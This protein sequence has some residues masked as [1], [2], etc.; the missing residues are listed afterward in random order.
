MLVA[1]SIR[2]IVLIEKADLDWQSGFTALTGETG[3]GKSVLLDALSLAIGQRGDAGLVRHGCPQGEVSAVF[4]LA[5]DHAV[6]HTLREGG[7]GDDTNSEVILRRIQSS[8]GRSRAFCNDKPI[9]IGLLREIGAQLV[10]IHGQHES[11]ALTDAA[12]QRDLLDA[13]GGLQNDCKNVAMAHAAW[14]AAIEAVNRARTSQSAD[15]A[16]KDF[17]THALAAL[18]ELAPETGEEES[19]A[20]L[21]HLLMN[22]EKITDDLSEAHRLLFENE[23]R[24]SAISTLLRRLEQTAPKAGGALDGVVAALDR[25]L[26]ETEEA[27]ARVREAAEGISSD[28]QRLGT[29]EQRLFA[30]RD[31]ARKHDT[32]CDNLPA[33]A[34]DMATRLAAL[35]DGAGNLAT[36][37]AAATAAEAAYAKSAQRLSQ[38][39]HKTAQALDKRVNKELPPLKLDG[40]AF[41]TRIDTTTPQEG[42]AHGLDRIAFEAATNHGTPP[43]PIAKIA[44]GGE[45]ARFMLALKVA[46]AERQDHATLIFDEVDAGVGGAVAEAVGVRLH[47]LA[48]GAQVLVVTHAPQVAARATHHYLVSKTDSHTQFAAL[49]DEKRRHEIARMLS[50]AAITDEAMAAAARLLAVAP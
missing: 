10:E 29:I 9:S 36:L 49:P 44:S 43:A 26:L 15:A 25:M 24:D 16:Q 3:A 4:S 46:L 33:L 13:F 22:A 1:L 38:A 40:G 21:R 12:T 23:E 11:Q 17:L 37:E 32:T 45:L 48:A 31:A 2:D 41:R 28:P 42:A 18:Q 19:L 27:R 34:Q 47:K 8:D 35:D 50:G 30:L 7:L 14:Q 6:Q 5:P 39:R 20:Q